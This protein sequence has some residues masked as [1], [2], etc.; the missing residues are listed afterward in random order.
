MTEFRI[1]QAGDAAITIAGPPV[2]DP[3]VNAWCVAVAAACRGRLGSIARDIVVGFSTVTVYF[4]PLAVEGT[5]VEG[6]AAAAARDASAA[7][8]ETSEAM[9]DVPVCYGGAFGPDLPEIAARAGFSEDEVV[10]RHV[11]P[12]YRVYLL[13]FLPGFA[14]MASVDPGIATPRRSTP[15]RQ[16]P[17]G[18][19]GIAGRQTGIYPG[20]APGG[21]NLVG[22]TPVRP[23]DPARR[24]PFL[25][26]PG[27]RVRFRAV[28]AAEYT[29]LEEP[30]HTSA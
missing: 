12:V 29:A 20:A 10:A 17:P 22:R 7:E 14:Y 9:L 30:C 6:E 13:G 27:D 26:R 8:P 1:L 15:R 3:A 2:I 4:D 5:W 24:D 18:S 11:G 16:V 23:Y 21:W 25:F 28:T 19:V